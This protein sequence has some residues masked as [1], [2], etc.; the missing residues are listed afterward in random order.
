MKLKFQPVYFALAVALFLIEVLIALYMHDAI[1]RPYGG[2]FLVV[3]F[4]YCFVMSFIQL[5]VIPAAI[6]VLLFAYAVEGAQYL[7]L[8]DVLGLSQSRA[9]Q[10]I[11]G[12][13]FMWGDMLAYTLGAGLVVVVEKMRSPTQT[14]PGREG[15]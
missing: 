11:L 7:H 15:F 14:L 2:D 1:I 10:L 12:S 5:P 8:I 4:L 13:T 6:G 3:I 9:A